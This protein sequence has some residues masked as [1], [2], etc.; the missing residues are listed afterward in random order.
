MC[1]R[2]QLSIEFR[3]RS[4][5]AQSR[6]RPANEGQ[7]ARGGSVEPVN[8]LPDREYPLEAPLFSGKSVC[9]SAHQAVRVVSACRSTASHRIKL[10]DSLCFDCWCASRPNVST[11]VTRSLTVLSQQQLSL[12]HMLKKLN[13]AVCHTQQRSFG[14]QSRSE[15]WRLDPLDRT[16]QA[17]GPKTS[18]PCGGS[19]STRDSNDCESKRDATWQIKKSPLRIAKRHCGG[20]GFW[21]EGATVKDAQRN[22]GL[23][24]PRCS[25]SSI[26]RWTTAIS[27]IQRGPMAW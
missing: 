3:G 18:G 23:R 25:R 20:Y 13:A 26:L 27:A 11:C 9:Q 6:A 10:L 7:F 12:S 17:E 1:A 16:S 5:P 4:I 8:E 22:F 19:A 15:D 21:L 24:G 2:Q 14:G